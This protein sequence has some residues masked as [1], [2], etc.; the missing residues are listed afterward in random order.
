MPYAPAPPS[1][2]RT[3]EIIVGE[4][5]DQAI[6]AHE[7]EHGPSGGA[8]NI[9]M[10]LDRLHRSAPSLPDNVGELVERLRAID[11]GP[12]EMMAAV[13]ADVWLRNPDGPDAA[14]ALT[15]YAERVRV[16]EEALDSMTAMSH[17]PP[18]TM[19]SDRTA[20]KG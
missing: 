7:V 2:N 18:T 10:I 20:L 14:D 19:A 11:D 9:S 17:Q 3:Q 12:L 8:W 15:A 4:W 13:G 6:R 1:N 5:F 16:L